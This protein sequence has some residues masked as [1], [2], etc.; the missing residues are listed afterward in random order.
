MTRDFRFKSLNNPFE[1]DIRLRL[2]S[3]ASRDALGIRAQTGIEL[4]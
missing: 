4:Q 2:E 1:I 3:Q